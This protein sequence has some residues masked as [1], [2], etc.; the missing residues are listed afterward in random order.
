MTLVVVLAGG[1]GSRMGGGKPL[2]KLGGETLLARAL[3]MARTWSE[4]VRIG[5]RSA[6]QIPGAD[7]PLVLD[8]PT[9]EGPLA[10]LVAAISTARDSGHEAVL[11]VPCDMPFLPPDLLA[12]LAERI[13]DK[14]AAVSASGGRLHPVCALWKVSSLAVLPAYL[15]TGRRSLVG[16]AEA[17]GFER[18]DWPGDL[19][20]NI[21][22]P[23]EL[24]AAE[25]RLAL[26][27]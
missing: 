10:G 8:D 7:V 6:D 9:I 14:E 11:T 20:V 4:D 26:E 23:S 5:L 22:T 18:V 2:R 1:E 15:A 3:R 27:R 16:F 24:A 19:F 12:R 25:Q 21:N 13:G 17:A